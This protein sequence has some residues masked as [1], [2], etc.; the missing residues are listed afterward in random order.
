MPRR[1]KANVRVGKT[2]IYSACNV[3]ARTGLFMATD[4]D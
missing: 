2:S 4:C 1:R 3:S